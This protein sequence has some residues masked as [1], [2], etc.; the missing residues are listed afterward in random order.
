MHH[1][2]KPLGNIM[3]AIL[4]QLGIGRKVRQ[5]GIVDLWPHIVGERIAQVTKIE[6]IEG[7]KLFVS[8]SSSAWRNELMFLKQELIIKVNAA[9]D[10]QLINDIIFR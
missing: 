6:R 3:S 7:D 4:E 10:G 5:Y 9:L 1:D 2:A 8:V